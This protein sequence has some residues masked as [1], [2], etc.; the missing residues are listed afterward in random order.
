MSPN[1]FEPRRLRE[2][3]Q[4]PSSVEGRLARQLRVLSVFAPTPQLRRYSALPRRRRY[5]LATLRGAAVATVVLAVS[6]VATATAAYV[7][8]RVWPSPAT[9]E[10]PPASHRSVQGPAQSRRP[11]HR[12]PPSETAP[13][14]VPLP[15][16]HPP[17]SRA[18]TPHVTFG[19]RDCVRAIAS[20][21]RESSSDAT[22]T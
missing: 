10:T 12:E 15:G 17:A 14:R 16:V 22:P 3:P 5:V 1:V 6:G 13:A 18:V 20:A 19:R 21:T 7:V 4:G 9:V 11:Y 2:S 8:R